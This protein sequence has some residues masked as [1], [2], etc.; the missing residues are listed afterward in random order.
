MTPTEKFDNIITNYIKN[1]E[2]DL[3]DR[4]NNWDKVLTAPEQYE[5]IGGLMARQITITIN[6]LSCSSIWNGH[7]API[8][9][10][11][12]IDSF[13]NFAWIFEDIVS[14]TPKSSALSF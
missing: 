3:T 5:V 10:R 4:W 12:L 8:I 7:I 1:I 6:F 13:I 9:L 14:K 2:E 11:S